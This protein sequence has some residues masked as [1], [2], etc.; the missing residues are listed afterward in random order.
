MITVYTNG[1]SGVGRALLDLRTQNVIRD[2]KLLARNDNVVDDG[3]IEYRYQ[4]YIY[5]PL[6]G[7]DSSL[8][9]SECG[10]FLFKSSIPDWM[11]EIYQK[12]RSTRKP[13]WFF[14]MDAQKPQELVSVLKLNPFRSYYSYQRRVSIF[15]PTESECPGIYST[16]FKFMA[17]FVKLNVE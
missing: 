3:D 1:Y 17:D 14:D 8:M 2:L 15:G 9:K 7:V 4:P 5:H 16:T 13:A 11:T 6:G 10:L 12:M